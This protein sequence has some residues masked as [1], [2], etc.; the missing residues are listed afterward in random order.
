MNK[1]MWKRVMNFC[2]YQISSHGRVKSKIGKTM[3]YH[4]S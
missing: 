3:K 4:I 1:E 2:D